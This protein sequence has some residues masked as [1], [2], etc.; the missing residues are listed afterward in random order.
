[1]KQNISTS[2]G[3]ERWLGR[4]LGATVL[5]GAIWWYAWP[6]LRSDRLFVTVVALNVLLFASAWAMMW[7]TRRRREKER[8]SQLERIV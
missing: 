4:L 6:W 3:S 7:R 2:T 8:A 5:V 1:M